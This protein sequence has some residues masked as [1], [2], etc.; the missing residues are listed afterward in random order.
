[1]AERW[2]DETE[3]LVARVLV[4]HQAEEDPDGL[5]LHCDCGGWAMLWRNS[6]NA[7]ARVAHRTHQVR[8]IL[9][10][11]AAVLVPPGGETRVEWSVTGDEGGQRWRTNHVD[12]AAADSHVSFVARTYP[13]LVAGLAKCRRIVT[14]HAGPWVEEATP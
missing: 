10:A 5:A 4:A 13:E 7:D 1:V 8:S 11:I 2:T 3:E 9:T 14:E 12:E 6:F